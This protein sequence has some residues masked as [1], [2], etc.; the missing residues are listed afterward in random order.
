K[1]GNRI[2]KGVRYDLLIQVRPKSIRAL[3]DGVEI[4]HYKF[5]VP[6]FRL[7]KYM[8][9]RDDMAPGLANWYGA[10]QYYSVE[11]NDFGADQISPAADQMVGCW[12]GTNVGWHENVQFKPDRSFLIER[13]Y[14]TG[15]WEINDKLLTMKWD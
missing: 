8:Q 5:N 14:V 15:K 9:L 2:E 7:L 11:I 10:A 1:V 3:L 13:K 4:T 6:N 12:S